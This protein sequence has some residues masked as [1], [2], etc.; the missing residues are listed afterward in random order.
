MTEMM[1]VS[2]VLGGRRVK[3]KGSLGPATV[4]GSE[5]ALTPTPAFADKDNLLGQVI[6]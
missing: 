3:A 6:L 2:V 5:V 4:E 1:Q